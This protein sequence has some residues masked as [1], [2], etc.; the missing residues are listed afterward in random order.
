MMPRLVWIAAAK[1]IFFCV[2]HILD[3]KPANQIAQVVA[4]AFSKNCQVYS[5][6]SELF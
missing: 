4:I 3:E 1:I 6:N 2:D 5:G